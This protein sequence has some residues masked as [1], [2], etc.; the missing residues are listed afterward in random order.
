M[1]VGELIAK[2][3]QERGLSQ[4]ELAKLLGYK[5]RATIHKIEKGREKCPEK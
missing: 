3:R 2:Y 4:E 1:T 5:S